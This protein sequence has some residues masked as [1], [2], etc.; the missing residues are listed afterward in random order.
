[1]GH[2]QTEIHEATEVPRGSVGPTLHRLEERG[3]VRHKGRYWAVAEDDRLAS[4]DATGHGWAAVEARDG[5]DW[6][7]RNP[8][9]A[10]DA[11]HARPVGGDEAN[12]RDH[13]PTGDPESSG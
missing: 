3:L 12:Y 1:M 9:W 2:T 4:V 8:N 5:D 7:A 10:A 11:E 6:Y 13:E